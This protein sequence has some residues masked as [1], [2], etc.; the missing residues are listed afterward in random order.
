MSFAA[1]ATRSTKPNFFKPQASRLGV[2]VLGVQMWRNKCAAGTAIV[3]IFPI[4][5][6][7]RQFQKLEKRRVFSVFFTLPRLAWPKLKM[8]C[9]NENN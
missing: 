6:P 2:F 4:N 3:S 7:A 5:P 9:Q 8:F 1:P